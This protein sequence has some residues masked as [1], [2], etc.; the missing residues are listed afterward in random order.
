VAQWGHV[1]SDP[2]RY[3]KRE[4]INLRFDLRADTDTSLVFGTVVDEK[5]ENIQKGEPFMLIDF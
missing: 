2:I 1:D 5:F 4:K 3:T